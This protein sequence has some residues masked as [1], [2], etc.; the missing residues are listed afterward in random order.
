VKELLI[1]KFNEVDFKES[2]ENII[3]FIKNIEC[4]NIWSKDFLY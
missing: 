3:S 2:K 4:L 1:K